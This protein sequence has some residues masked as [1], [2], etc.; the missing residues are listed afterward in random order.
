MLNKIRKFFL[1]G[2]LLQSVQAQR[3]NRFIP[4]VHKFDYVCPTQS[5]QSSNQ[6]R[7]STHI[8]E[9]PGNVM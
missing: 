4:C 8:D 6:R 3:W 1:E 7:R 2:L 5:L 9:P